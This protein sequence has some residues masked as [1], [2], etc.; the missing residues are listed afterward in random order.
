MH[1]SL[2]FS[3]HKGDTTDFVSNIT[4]YTDILGNSDWKCLSTMWG[5][6]FK[7]AEIL[8]QAKEEKFKSVIIGS[9]PV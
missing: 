5:S 7:L 2:F 1:A 3:S 8:V 4:N 6:Q 9:L